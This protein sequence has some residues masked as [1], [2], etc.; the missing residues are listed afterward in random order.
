MRF[1]AE[2][3]YRHPSVAAEL[4]L[5]W[6]DSESGVSGGHEEGGFIVV[7]DFGTLSAVRWERGTQN[8]IV[9]PPHGN[10]LVGG[11]AIVASFH[12]H[13]NTGADF[14]QEPSLNDVRAV[15]DDPALKGEFYLGE[16]VV[17][18]ENIYLI[19]PSGRVCVFGK[20]SEIFQGQKP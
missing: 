19:E 9:L 20:T 11:K 2:E 10:C 14:E 17:S 15:R 4:K 3:L 5:A 8:E 16:F 1:S 13:P 12:T 18:Q 6:Q 7:D